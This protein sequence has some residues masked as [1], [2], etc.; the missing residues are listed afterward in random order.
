M[1]HQCNIIKTD[2]DKLSDIHDIIERGNHR[3]L[4]EILTFSHNLKH[5]YKTTIELLLE[6]YDDNQLKTMKNIKINE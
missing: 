6:I 3:K 2:D 5:N 4:K 1:L